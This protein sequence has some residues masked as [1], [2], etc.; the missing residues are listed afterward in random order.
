MGKTG[1]LFPPD[2]KR[3]LKDILKDEGEEDMII[4]NCNAG[5]GYI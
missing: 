5:A 2:Y 1:M 3:G 4:R